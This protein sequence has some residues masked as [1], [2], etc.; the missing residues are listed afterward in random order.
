MA[1]TYHGGENLIAFPWGDTAHCPGFP[2]RC[3]GVVGGGG[4]LAAWISPDHSALAVCA[5]APRSSLLSRAPLFLLFRAPALSEDGHSL[6]TT[7]GLPR[8][9]LSGRLGGAAQALAMHAADFAGSL[10]S[11]PVLTG[12]VS[13]LAPY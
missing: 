2:G 3:R 5:P 7:G 4:R 6:V 13:S 9:G 12:H 8:C 11:P 1:V 10:P